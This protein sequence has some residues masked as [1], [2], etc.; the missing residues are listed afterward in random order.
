MVSV[1]GE[2]GRAEVLGPPVQIKYKLFPLDAAGRLAG[3]R[4]EFKWYQMKYRIFIWHPN[5]L[6]HPAKPSTIFLLLCPLLGPDDLLMRA[7]LRI[8]IEKLD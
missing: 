5:V 6:T 7:N 1:I 2:M 4:L 3:I 8:I